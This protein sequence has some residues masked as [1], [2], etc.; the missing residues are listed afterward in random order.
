MTHSITEHQR[1]ESIPIPRVCALRQ[2]IQKRQELSLLHPGAR[3][4]GRCGSSLP[5]YPT[6]TPTASLAGTLTLVF[7]PSLSLTLSLSLSLPLTLTLHLHQV[8]PLQL[9]PRHARGVQRPHD[10][11]RPSHGR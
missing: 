8:R 1:A 6:L 10:A 11:P 2:V 3:Q 4:C 5:R 7:P 9:W